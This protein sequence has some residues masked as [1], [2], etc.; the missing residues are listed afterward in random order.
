MQ[1]ASSR[2]VSFSRIVSSILRAE[3]PFEHLVG[4]GSFVTAIPDWLIV[5]FALASAALALYLLLGLTTP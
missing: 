2:G 4:R 1:G 3:A 5:L